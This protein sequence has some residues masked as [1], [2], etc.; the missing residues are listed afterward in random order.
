MAI[1]KESD[2]FYMT[3]SA[4]VRKITC[5]SDEITDEHIH[6]FFEIVYILKGKSVHF[7]D[8]REYHLKHGDMLVINYNSRHSHTAEIGLQYVNIL[9]KPQYINQSLANCENAFELLKLSEFEQFRQILDESKCKIT[10]SGNEREKIE[11]II[12]IFLDELALNPT[13]YE[14]TVRSLFNVVLLFIFRKMA[15]DMDGTFNGMSEKVLSYIRNNC[16][17]KLTLEAMASKCSYNPSYFSRL[18]KEYT[19]QTF[20]DY[21]KKVRMEK[22]LDLIAN[23]DTDILSI[24]YAVGYSEKS[25]FYKHFKEH[26]GTTPLKFRKSMKQTPLN[27]SAQERDEFEYDQAE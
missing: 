3:E 9:L 5:L 14:L 27:T 20:M 7:V 12:S 11:S 18:F 1:T 2:K 22:A 26:T 6:D 4:Y 23:R 24:A 8:A 15:L 16:S 17:K 13:G 19:G 25:K 21:L 10:F